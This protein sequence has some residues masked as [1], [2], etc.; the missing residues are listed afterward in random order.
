M[1]VA[2][3]PFSVCGSPQASET[4]KLGYTAAL[5][6]DEA[7]PCHIVVYQPK[8]DTFKTPLPQRLVVY[9]Y[10]GDQDGKILWQCY[11]GDTFLEYADLLQYDRVT[12]IEFADVDD[13][14]IDE[15]VIS[16]D[17]DCMGSGWIQTLEVLDYDLETKEF[18]SYK[19]VTA[20]GPF[21]GFMVDSLDSEG[22]VQR[23]FA[24]SY[25]SDG[26]DT[27]IGGTECR[28]CPHRYRVAVYE[29]TDEGL[30]V[31]PRWNGGQIAY[32]QLRFPCG[33]SGNPTDEYR[34]LNEYYMRSSLYN[35]LDAGPPF[36]VL[37]P[38]PN[39]TVSL[40]FSLRV[41]IPQDMPELGIKIISTSP[42]GNE[43][44]LLED[45]IEGWAYE[46]GTSLKVEDSV[47]YAAPSGTSGGIILYDPVNPDD[48]DRILRIP[49]IFELVETKI[50]QVYFP[51]SQTE[52]NDL[53]F[54]VERTIPVAEGV[55]D[56]LARGPTGQEEAMGY[57]TYL[58][59]TCKAQNFYYVEYPC[60]ATKLWDI[61][62]ENG[63]VRFTPHDFDTLKAI[64]QLGRAGKIAREEIRQTLL[65][66]PDVMSVTF[67]APDG[68]LIAE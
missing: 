28:W 46:P 67:W 40:P 63:V 39:Q 42:N 68:S 45:I 61:R 14:G 35:A 48:A 43:K 10:S 20:S 26:M 55:M 22:N 44:I 23:I 8:G 1:V 37:S 65:Q 66:F 27:R 4:I 34:S 50:V 16:W 41:E 5:T 17:S 47:Y 33:G 64:R 57:F 7:R 11:R 53:V 60:S 62:I 52:S 6:G 24:Y 9:D 25:K 36:V 32:T 2:L 30:V 19:G 15:T 51:N 58:L 13:D 21:G 49:V 56:Q 31:D 54:P 12:K 18:R 29:I 38:Q 3:L 59:P